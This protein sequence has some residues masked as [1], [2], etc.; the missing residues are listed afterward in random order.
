MK[1]VNLKSVAGF[2]MVEVLV[3]L[4]LICIG[5]LGVVA[6]QTRN[7]QYTQNSSQRNTAAMLANDLIEQIRSNRDAVLNNGGN[8]STTSTY[9]KTPATVF[10]TTGVAAC[11]TSSGCSADQMATDQMVLWARQVS[12]ALPTDTFLMTSSY[13]ICVDSTPT[14]DACDNIGSAIKVQL[15]WYSQENVSCAPNQ[16]CGVDLANRREYYRVSFEP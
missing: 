7:I 6:M 1:T 16:P 11:R 12:N 3:S 14:T 2:T 15:A 13:V 9:Y 4:L 10:P 5:V 8:V